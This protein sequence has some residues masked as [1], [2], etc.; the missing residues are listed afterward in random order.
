[1]DALSVRFAD[2]MKMTIS[3]NWSGAELPAVD[4]TAWT[5]WKR[6]Q[7]GVRT[8]TESSHSDNRTNPVSDMELE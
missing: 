5:Y 2:T 8:S 7:Y 1:M 4:V 6:I 3:L